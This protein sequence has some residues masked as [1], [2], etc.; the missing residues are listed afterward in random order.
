[1]SESGPELAISGN[2]FDPSV[3]VG[4]A[5]T[6]FGIAYPSRLKPWKCS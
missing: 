1:M 4:G 5:E 2:A 3:E 6:G